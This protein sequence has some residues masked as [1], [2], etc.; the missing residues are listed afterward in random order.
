LYQA[1][2]RFYE[3]YKT[4]G[5]VDLNDIIQCFLDWVNLDEYFVIRKKI[6]SIGFYIQKA[7]VRK[8]SKRGND[9]YSYRVSKRFNLLYDAL[10]TYEIEKDDCYVLKSDI[11]FFTLTYN[12]RDIF[13][14][15][16]NAGKDYNRFM[17]NLRKIFPR[18]KTIVRCFEAQKDGVLH[19]HALIW[20]G[21]HI[22]VA[23]WFNT[24][25]VKVFIVK[26]YELWLKLKNCWKYGFCDIKG[27]VRFRDG[28]KY[29]F[30]YI[31]KATDIDYSDNSL[32]TLALNWLFRKRSFSINYKL[33]RFLF[34]IRVHTTNKHNSNSR[35]I[36]QCLGLVIEYEFIGIFSKKQLGLENDRW[37]YEFDEFPETLINLFWGKWET[38]F[39]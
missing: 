35:V 3:Q 23:P 38:S 14:T 13:R 7:L 28:L 36:L 18:A 6:Y 33:L 11:L 1:R 34:N 32:T 12:V 4:Q 24:E 8:C 37:F 22:D 26:S 19:I 30:K 9:V 5:F 16:E 21:T 27:F 15:Y 17:S 29:I 2:L 31:K 39:K 20:I 10:G 25:G